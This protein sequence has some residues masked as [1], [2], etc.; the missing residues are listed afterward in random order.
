MRQDI[1]GLLLQPSFADTSSTLPTNEPFSNGLKFSDS[2]VNL[3]YQKTRRLSFS[4]SIEGS[5][6]RQSTPNIGTNSGILRGDVAYRL[7]RRSTVAL[8]C[9]LS[10]FSYTTFGSADVE[11]AA[12]DY[13]WRATKSVD[14]A[15]QVG[16]DH[17][18]S[19]ALAIVPIDPAIAALIGE[20]TGIQV[21]DRASNTPRMNAL[22][23][24]RWHH[25]SANVNYL[26]GISPGNGLV[27]TSKQESLTAGLHY[28]FGKNWTASVQGGRTTL[29]QLA[30]AGSYAQYTVSSSFSRVIRPGVQ[31]VG[32][33]EVRPVN[34]VGPQ[35]LN[36]TFYLAE[37]GFAFSP[38]QIPIALR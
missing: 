27:L 8:D 10:R 31:A 30:A 26:R 6:M 11:G 16:M 5:L 15:L 2:V 32:R 18:G 35:G 33:F 28:S 12:V 7:T 25:A 17:S 23:T 20:G 36:R 14:V 4:G 34:Y 24:K 19:V 38:S 3:T 37:I 22:V 13:T 29:E 9:S 21:A 1:G